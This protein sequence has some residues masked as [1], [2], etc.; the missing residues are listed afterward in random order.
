MS[1]EGVIDLFENIKV[2]F[3]IETSGIYNEIFQ[4]MLKNVDTY[5][6]RD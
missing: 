3:S 4:S 6:N 5:L 2:Q 1:L